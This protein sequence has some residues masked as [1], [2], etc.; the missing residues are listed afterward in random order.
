MDKFF[1]VGCPRSGTTMV[2]QALNRH[3]QIAIPPETKFFFSFLGHSR[4]CQD[5]HIKRLNEDLNIRL[6][7]PATRI[8]S[9]EEGRAFYEDMARQYV[10]GLRKKNV[11]WFGEKTPEH[12]GHLPRIRQLFPSA[13]IL[14]IYRDGRDVALSLTKTPWMPAGLYISFLVWLYYQRTI[15]KAKS[16]GWPGLYFVRYESVVADP[17]KEFGRILDFLGAPYE[18]AVAHGWGS[19]EGIPSRE[20][21]WKRRAMQRI[22]TDRVGLFRRE[23]SPD[24]LAVLERLGRRELVSLGYPLMTDGA[25]QLSPGLLL[26]LSR[27]LAAFLYRMPWHCVAHE[28]FGLSFLCGR[29]YSSRCLGILRSLRD[30]L[31]GIATRPALPALPELE[32]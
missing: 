9:V 8:R 18:P 11:A 7:R 4:Q 2:Q 1:V 15:Q 13:K 12:T 31:S 30:T 19:S 5:R 10:A 25:G 6:P 24:Q 27:D 32:A 21:A 26:N 22:T 28:L 14:V 20:Y 16:S 29:E 17:E 3:S 23:L